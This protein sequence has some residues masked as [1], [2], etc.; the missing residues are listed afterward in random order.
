MGVLQSVDE[1]TISRA[2]LS[3]IFGHDSCAVGLGVEVDS[4][5]E[6]DNASAGLRATLQ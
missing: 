6:K 2:R 3:M 5:G 1:P 4:N